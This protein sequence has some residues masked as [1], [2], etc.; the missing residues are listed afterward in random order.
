[1][2]RKPDI[3]DEEVGMHAFHLRKRTSVE[4]AMEKIRQGLGRKFLQFTQEDIEILEWVLGETWAMMGFYEWQHIVFSEL[5]SEQLDK[6]INIGNEIVSHRK[7]GIIGLE[8]VHQI[9]K[10]ESL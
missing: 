6:I 5:K 1:M 2:E 10:E 7:K 9:L 4:R 8:E 3:T